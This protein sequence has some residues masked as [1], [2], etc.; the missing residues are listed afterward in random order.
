[1][2]TGREALSRAGGGSP[3]VNGSLPLAAGA[4][5]RGLQG[6]EARAGTP[7]APLPPTPNGRAPAHPLSPVQPWWAVSSF[8][9]KP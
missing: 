1:M 6:P 3:L 8:P 5:V 7:A 9:T 2:S 4:T